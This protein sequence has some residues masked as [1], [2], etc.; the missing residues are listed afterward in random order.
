MF[1]KHVA[2]SALRSPQ[3]Q[4]I[5]VFFYIQDILQCDSLLIS[6]GFVAFWYSCTIL[7]Y[8]R[9]NQSCQTLCRTATYTYLNMQL[10]MLTS[11]KTHNVITHTTHN[12][13]MG[14]CCV[15]QHLQLLCFFMHLF[16]FF[17]LSVTCLYWQTRSQDNR[18]LH[19]HQRQLTK[20]SVIKTH[21]LNKER[22]YSGG[23]S[24]LK[25]S[26]W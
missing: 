1:V 14:F 2:P 13:H 9:Y 23:W 10:Y 16:R 3:V 26:V 18:H 20:W 24:E 4:C 12:L 19:T 15:W 11:W 5:S 21:R 22:L 6:R 17:L 7:Q 8:N 25:Q